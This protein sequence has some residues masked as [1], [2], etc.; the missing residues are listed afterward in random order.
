MRVPS[1]GKSISQIFLS[2]TILSIL[3]IYAVAGTDL[4]PASKHGLKFQ[5]WTMEV[6]DRPWM[7]IDLGMAL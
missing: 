7:L 4:Y 3:P 2:G 5:A 1:T 6:L